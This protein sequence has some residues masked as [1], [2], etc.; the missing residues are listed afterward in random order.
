MRTMIVDERVRIDG[1]D[2]VTVRPISSEVG[3][4]PRVH[5]SS[6]FTR[7]ETQGIVTV[8]L[9]T[10]QDEQKI[11]ALTG[12]RW[13]RFLL[14]YNFPPYSVGEVKPIRSPGRREVGHGNLAERALARMIPSSEQFPYTIRIVSEITESNG[15]SS[16]AT[17]CGG[18]LSLMDAGVPIRAP[19][20]G[21]A[22]EIGR[23]HV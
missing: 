3:L 9:G 14:H 23:A 1:R 21:V 22:M 12:E 15:S 18:T 2:T 13:K 7:G 5:G 16:M 19:V 17:V 4:L 8:T 11:D 10:S 6:L 20:A